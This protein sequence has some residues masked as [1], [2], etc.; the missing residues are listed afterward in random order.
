[1][2]GV[3]QALGAGGMWLGLDPGL[4]VSGD[5]GTVGFGDEKWK[6]WLPVFIHLG[7]LCFPVPVAILPGRDTKQA[8]EEIQR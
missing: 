6:R 8:N 5:L 7:P 3:K 4:V 1:M 2:E